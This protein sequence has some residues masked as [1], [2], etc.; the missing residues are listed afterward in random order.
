MDKSKSD[1]EI[2]QDSAVQAAALLQAVGNPH[3]LLVLCLLMAEDEMTVGALNGMVTLSPSALSQHL[4]KMR[5][6]G[7]I[8]YR[9]ESQTLYYRIDDPR[10]AKLIGT[11]KDI[12]C[13]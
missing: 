12:F 5:E 10:V 4:A 13:P 11:L 7:L 2:L 6:E 1:L 9:R 3:R 8:T